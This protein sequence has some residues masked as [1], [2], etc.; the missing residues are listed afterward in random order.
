MQ[1][2]LYGVVQRF[3]IM[4]QI[5]LKN[6][7][8]RQISLVRRMKDEKLKIVIVKDGFEYKTTAEL[9]T[10]DDNDL[11]EE[12]SLKFVDSLGKR[13]LFKISHW[14]PSIRMEFTTL[15][16]KKDVCV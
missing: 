2:R 3:F 11:L 15:K 4:K 7:G 16:L 1:W 8:S 6:L 14:M 13:N 9:R 10:D 5:N 12:L